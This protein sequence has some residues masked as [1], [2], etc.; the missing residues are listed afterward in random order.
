MSGVNP[1]VSRRVGLARAISK[2]GHCSRSRAVD[3]I[4]AGHVALNGK[5][6]RDPETP[7]ALTKDR[8]DID[9]E[10]VRATS[11]VYLILNKPRGIVTTSADEK[12][13]QTIHDF[14]PRNIPFVAAVGR[15]DKASEGLLLVTND[16]EWSARIQAPATHVEKTYHVQV[17]VVADDTLLN[18]IQRGVRSDGELL[19]A[20]RASILR[21]GQKSSWLEIVLDEGK[22]RHIRR[23]L[24]QLNIEV[25]RLVRVAIGPLQL[26]SLGKGSSR[27]LTLEEKSA[28]DNAI[29]IAVRGKA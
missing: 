6:R 3:L 9:G 18:A 26:G 1:K 10:S 14:L 22:N 29:N 23:M 13:R 8:I 12:G 28:L 16:S 17:N 24:K 21:T 4:R 7:V 5:I 15:L 11:K 2:L 19:R 27:A 25:L 20:K